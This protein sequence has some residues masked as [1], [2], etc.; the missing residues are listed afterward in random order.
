[1]GL[2][3]SR[4]L[5][6]VWQEHMLLVMET[7]VSPSNTRNKTSFRTQLT[8]GLSIKV[9]VLTKHMVEL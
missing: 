9:P 3:L 7:L 4:H 1:M 6:Q 5:G 2:L 8:M